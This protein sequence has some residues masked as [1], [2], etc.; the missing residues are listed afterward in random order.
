MRD[1]KVRGY[2]V[3][4]LCAESQWVEGFGVLK[5]ELT[6]GGYDYILFTPYGNYEVYGESVG[7]YT[8]LKDKNG[9]EIYEGDVITFEDAHYSESENGQEF[10]V[11][12]NAGVVEW[13]DKQPQFYVTNRQSVDLETLFDYIEESEVIGNIYENPNIFTA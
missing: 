13:E 8:G 2:A 12:I 1:I 4:K 6:N 10:D 5:T 3:E 7:Q 9:K 11:F